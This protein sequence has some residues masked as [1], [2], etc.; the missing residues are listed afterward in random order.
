MYDF[1]SYVLTF[2]EW[3]IL[4]FSKLK[5]RVKYIPKKHEHLLKEKL[6]RL[7]GDGLNSSGFPNIDGTFSITDKGN[8]FLIYKR[9]KFFTGKFPVFISLLAFIGAYR[10]EILWLLQEAGK[11]LKSI[12]AI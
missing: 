2:R 6:I 7:N 3:S 4:K 5:K 11:L 12:M 8:R 1:S 9:E 10:K